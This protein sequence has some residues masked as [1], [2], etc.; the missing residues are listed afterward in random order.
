MTKLSR[1][2]ELAYKTV[3]DVCSNPFHDVN[4][5]TLARI[6]EALEVSVHELVEDVPP[7]TNEQ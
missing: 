6:Q 4:L 7:D 3:Q 5:S 1:K 2:A